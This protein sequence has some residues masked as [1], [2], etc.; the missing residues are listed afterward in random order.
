[1]DDLY[2]VAPGLPTEKPAPRAA[3]GNS[4]NRVDKIKS[5]L[6]AKRKMMIA[7]T[8][9]KGAITIDGDYLRVEYAP[10]NAKCKAEIESRDKRIAIEDACEQVLGQRLTLRASVAGQS[11]GDTKPLRKEK[12]KAAL[13]DDPKLRALIDKFH[14]EVI[15]VIKPEQ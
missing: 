11:G 3:A 15:E 14:G 12:A 7:S 2:K 8:L 4:D 5:A 10:E 6:E 9:D 1:M 13:E